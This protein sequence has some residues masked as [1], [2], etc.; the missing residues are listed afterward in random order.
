M[1]DPEGLETNAVPQKSTARGRGGKP[2]TEPHEQE[3]Q[4]I[5]DDGTSRRGNNESGRLAAEFA[6]I[7][8]D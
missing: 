4:P 5:W 1:R 2:E 8:V 7:R 6:R 3:M